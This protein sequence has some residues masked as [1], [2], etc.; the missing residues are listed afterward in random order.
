MAGC[1][2]R[3]LADDEDP[4]VGHRLAEC[5]QD[6]VAGRKVG[7]AGGQLL[8]Q[9]GA[10]SSDV[11]G[12]GIQRLGPVRGHETRQVR[13][14]HERRPHRLDRSEM[15]WLAHASMSWS[16]T[17]RRMARMRRTLVR[18]GARMASRSVDFMPLMSYG[19][20][21][22]ACFSSAAAPA[23]SLKTSAPRSSY[24]Q[25]TNSLATRFMPSRSGVTTMTSAAR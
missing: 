11:V 1:R 7:M 16:R 10:R 15:N 20:T 18:W 21:W 4:D 14:G 19:L 5:P 23:N 24:W 2:V 6:A 12:Y 8:A 3:I 13:S 9:E 22:Y 25:A 17:V